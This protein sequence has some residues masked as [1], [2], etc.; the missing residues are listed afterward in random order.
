MQRLR[1]AEGIKGVKEEEFGR[2][3]ASDPEI[4]EEK[5]FTL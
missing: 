2:Y 4:F 3:K 5:G 1:E